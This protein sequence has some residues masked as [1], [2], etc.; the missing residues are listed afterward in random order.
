MFKIL[1]IPGSLRENSSSH[2]VLKAV[3]NM[4][5]EGV[6]F[7]VC[8]D[9]GM[10][11]LFN[12]PTDTPEVVI[13]FRKKISAADAVLIC[14]PEYAFGVPGA[15]KNALD[16]TVGTGE[17]YEK[18]LALITASSHGEKGHAAMLWILTAISAKISPE[19]TLLIS[20][21]R[22][23]IDAEGKIKDPDT[24]KQLQTVLDALVLHQE[25]K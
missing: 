6:S 10:L 22:S 11:P 17:F 3:S 14:T 24:N 21:V 25:I 1:G 5:P 4:V 2:A 12:D 23:K 7:E 16:W 20:F 13:D 15:L 9:I 19:A 8:N 18:P